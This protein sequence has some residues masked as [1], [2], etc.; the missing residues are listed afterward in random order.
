MRHRMWTL[1]LALLSSA[2]CSLVAPD[3]EGGS[4]GTA[5]VSAPASAQTASSPTEVPS[6]PDNIADAALAFIQALDAEQRTAAAYTFDDPARA[7]WSNLPAG[8]LGFKRNGVRI[9]DLNAAQTEAMHRFLAIALSPAGYATVIGIVG[10]EDV[11]AQAPQ[12][13]RLQWS[14]DNY[15]LAFFGEPAR[16]AS[17]AWQFGGH[18]LAVNVTVADGRS[19]MSPS[20]LGVEPASY[21]S[22]G[23]VIAPL[24]AQAE[25]G[26]ALVNALDAATRAT[27]VVRTR[28]RDLVTG[29]GQDGVIPALEG[30]RVGAWSVDQQRQLLDVVA[31]WTGLLPEASAQDRLAEVQA[32][33][34]DTYFAWYGAIDGNA[35]FYYRIQG[36]A[37]IIESSV[38]GNL[39]AEGGHYHSIYRDPTNEYGRNASSAS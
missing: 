3:E 1:I 26:L 28:A 35:E 10:A 9:G 23:S 22:G 17:W 2:G 39:G 30:A 12:A 11:L 33:L 18:H 14:A 38:E 24:A 21:E 36:P 16:N 5:D 29:A 19:Y 31:L 27:A 37:L 4:V 6:Q 13:R 7:N 20:F 8:R 15:W 34:A 32:A 25:A